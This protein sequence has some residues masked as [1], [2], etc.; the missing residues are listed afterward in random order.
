M[1]GLAAK[2]AVGWLP[3]TR[4]SV[5]DIFKHYLALHPNMAA[6]AIG[7]LVEWCENGGKRRT[8]DMIA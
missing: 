2:A 8:R 7:K 6:S 1:S 4:A 3:E 5:H